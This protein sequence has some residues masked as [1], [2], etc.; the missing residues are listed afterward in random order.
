MS[1]RTASNST[2]A[3]LTATPTRDRETRGRTSSTASASAK[4]FHPYRLPTPTPTRVIP[5]RKSKELGRARMDAE[6]VPALYGRGSQG[7]LLARRGSGTAMGSGNG[8]TASGTAGAGVGKAYPNP[9]PRRPTTAPRRSAPGPSANTSMTQAT[10][11][12]APPQPPRAP[13]SLAD[14]SDHDVFGPDSN[15]PLMTDLP[16]DRR[17]N[18]T[19]YWLE[20]LSGTYE[21]FTGDLGMGLASGSGS[22]TYAGSSTERTASGSTAFSTPPPQLPLGSPMWIARPL[23]SD[24]AQ[25]ERTSVDWEVRSS[26]SF[27]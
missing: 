10:P 12:G 2:V 21:A 16:A 11:T 4:K 17:P 24:Y 9:T 13:A 6:I 14:L 8:T 15:D 20:T 5:D 3:A 26:S 23:P 19:K 1:S 18:Y 22:G 25:S 27:I 7:V